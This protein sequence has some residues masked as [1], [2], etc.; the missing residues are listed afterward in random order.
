MSVLE[1]ERLCSESRG[2][3]LGNVYTGCG[4]CLCWRAEGREQTCETGVLT[5]AYDVMCL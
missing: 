4:L 1:A 3:E 2:N 5:G